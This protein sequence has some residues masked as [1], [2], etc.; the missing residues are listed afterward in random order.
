MRSNK[1]RRG[2][3]SSNERDRVDSSL[4]DDNK[5]NH[6]ES[7]GAAHLV[8]SWINSKRHTNYILVN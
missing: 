5:L 8:F 7:R 1:Q 4:T 6:G 2:N 3:F